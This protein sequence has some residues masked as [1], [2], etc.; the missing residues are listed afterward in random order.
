[1][2]YVFFFECRGLYLRF[3]WKVCIVKIIKNGNFKSNKR[4][5]GRFGFVVKVK[6]LLLLYEMKIENWMLIYIYLVL[7]TR[8]FVLLLFF[9]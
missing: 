5:L 8:N 3:I 7:F 9:S 4:I 6:N 2:R 1:M